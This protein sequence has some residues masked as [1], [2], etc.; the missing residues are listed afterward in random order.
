MADEELIRLSYC[1]TSSRRSHGG[2][3]SDNEIPRI[4]RASRTNNPPLKLGGV[5]HYGNGY[6]FQ[7]LEG[8]A[9]AVDALYETIRQDPRHTEVQTLERVPV[10]KRRFPDWS[11]KYVPFEE[12]IN[13]VLARH[14]LEAFDPYQ[15]GPA[16]IE[17]LITVLV[18]AQG[19]DRATDPDP[20]RPRSPG[21]WFHRW[22]RR[23]RGKGH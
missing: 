9:A 17:E 7:V 18:G 16:V 12:D 11:M 10:S 13:R 15:F 21:S 8:P 23:I 6:F 3:A 22:L 20:A 5:L 14:K 2:T 4:L 19:P 1:S